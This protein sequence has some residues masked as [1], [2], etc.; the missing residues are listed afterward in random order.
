M[1]RRETLLRSRPR[2]PL[3]GR[4]ANRKSF[5]RKDICP[6]SPARQGA[7]GGRMPAADLLERGLSTGPDVRK[8]LVFA[9][10]EGTM[11]QR[12]PRR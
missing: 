3:A 4:R 6:P 2:T 9:A 5:E 10:K 7:L 11:E 12:P 1:T 8:A